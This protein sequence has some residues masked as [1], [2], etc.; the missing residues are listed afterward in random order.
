VVLFLVLIALPQA[1]AD[2]M[3]YHLLIRVQTEDKTR[4]TSYLHVKII[5]FLLF[6][7]AFRHCY[8]KDTGELLWIRTCVNLMTTCIFQLLGY[9]LV[10]Q[11]ECSGSVQKKYLSTILANF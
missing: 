1:G 3:P 10:F 7:E 8:S 11:G 6:F 5:L 9:S 2:K 4:L